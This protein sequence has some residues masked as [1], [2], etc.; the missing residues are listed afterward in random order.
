MSYL[1]YQEILDKVLE[2][3]DLQDE[4][5][6]GPT[7]MMGYCNDAIKKVESQ[8]HT[9]YEDYF[10]N[11]APL[12]LT[13][14]QSAVDMPSDI[15]ANKIRSI[16]F[17]R[18][19]NATEIY[20]IVRIKDVKKF[21]RIEEAMA[22]DLTADYRYWIKNASPAQNGRKIMLVPPARE[23]SSSVAKVFYLRR[24]NKVLT[25]TDL[26]DIP[27]FYSVVVAYMRYMAYL[28]EGHPNTTE[29]KDLYLAEEKNMVETLTEMVPDGENELP[30]PVDPYDGGVE[31]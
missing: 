27:E 16:T 29:M 3:L 17:S 8:I 9:V 25:T 7:E 10:L 28:K 4:T 22:N 21:I 13:Q 23:T 2:P 26:V 14:G 5:F 15:Y 1:T 24:A 30:L 6:I 31:P 20:E 11:D 19:V 18:G 12:T